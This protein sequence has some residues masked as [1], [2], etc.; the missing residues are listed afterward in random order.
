M[1]ASCGNPEA[2]AAY[3]IAAAALAEGQTETAQAGFEEL[4]GQGDFVSES[5]RGIGIIQL[6]EDDPADACISFEKAL[7]YA[8][9]QE[10]DY[11]LDVEM[12]LAKARTLHGEA[13]KALTVYDEILA[14]QFDPEI[15]FLRGSL[16]LEK[17]E[18]EKAA[19]DFG[20]IAEHDVNS[21]LMIAIYDLYSGSGYLAEGNEYLEKIIAAG[22]QVAPAR[23]GLAYYYL[24][25]YAEAE[26][27]L[28]EAVAA[29]P[30]DEDAL[31]LLGQALL[32]REDTEAARAV[33]REY[34]VDGSAAGLNGLALCDMAEGLYEEALAKIEAG[35]ALEDEKVE[36]GLKF[37]EIAALEYL[38]RWDEAK[39]KAKAYTA[40]Y[41]T[42]EAGISE[43]AFLAS[44]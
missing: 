39:A 12:Y 4:I 3:E 16:L 37:N 34:A 22:D 8:D 28:R 38:G 17:G 25:E 1:L 30:E 32:A 18:A 33:F 7:L 5:W 40:A 27:A 13:D 19:A 44:R 31:M 9:D 14:E 11:F 15:A 42:D 2:K 6:M 10:E 26:E 43:N 41:P 35:L 29:D 36:Q 20:S 24:E 23:R 21:D